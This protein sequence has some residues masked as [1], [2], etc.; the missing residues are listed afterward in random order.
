MIALF[1][2]LA[3]CGG[4]GTSR[5]VPA[6]L[7]VAPPPEPPAEPA[8][9]ALDL[10]DALSAS[11]FLSRA[12]FG[13]SKDQVDALVGTEAGA[14]LE[15][16]FAKPLT[17]ML[18]AFEADALGAK[19]LTPADFNGA[20]WNALIGNDDQL[21]QR[22]VF[23]LSQIV[24][25]NESH[26]AGMAF[27]YD[28][29]QEHAF[30][31]YRDLLHDVTYTPAMARWLTYLHNR[32]TFDGQGNMPDE[33]YAREILQLFSSGTERL[34]MDGRPQLGADGQPI[35]TYRSMTSSVSRAS[36]P[37]LAAS[38]RATSFTQIPTGSSA[39]WRSTPSTTPTVRRP[40]SARP[41]RRAHRAKT[42]S[43]RPSTSSSPT[44][45]SRPSSAV[46]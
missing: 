37:G 21:R 6:P 46:S 23:A 20:A 36:S 19:A 12:T 4:G 1:A 2:G 43:P 10:P 7:I 18:P 22:M 35:E 31:N 27:Y 25:A 32:K 45:M 40:S 28:T 41:S 15:A 24:V 8:P 17:P 44:S 11:A 13:G 34:H 16:E 38:R 30:G 39:R 29:L 26:P 14:F 42:A 33:N 5:P 9:S 3:G